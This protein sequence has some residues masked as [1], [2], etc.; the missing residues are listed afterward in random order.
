MSDAALLEIRNLRLSVRTDEGIAQISIRGVG[1]A[2]RAYPR[3]R[4][5]VWLR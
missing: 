1:P 5:R 2:A 3:R 4:R